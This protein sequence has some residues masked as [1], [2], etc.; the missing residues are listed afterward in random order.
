MDN[1][2][3]IKIIEDF[4]FN[5]DL[6]DDTINGCVYHHDRYE[7]TKYSDLIVKRPSVNTKFPTRQI[8]LQKEF[9]NNSAINTY[10]N[11]SDDN[12][13]GMREQQT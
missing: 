13:N 3:D 6:D 9:K 7:E 11:Q 10:H 1:Y 8:I 4:H 5:Q 12:N 2:A